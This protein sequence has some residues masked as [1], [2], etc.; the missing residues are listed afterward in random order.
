MRYAEYAPPA[1]LA[2]FIRCFWTF[3]AS[4]DGPC[5]TETIVPD[6]HPELVFHHGDSYSEVTIDASGEA[7]MARQPQCL[8]AGQLT[9]PLRLQANGRRGM[10]GVRFQPAGAG[11]L[12]DMPMRDTTDRWLTLE[13][14]EL[15]W[16]ERAADAV[17]S[18]RDDRTRVAA[19][20][21]ALL[22]RLEQAT[23]LGDPIV[24]ACIGAMR[25]SL[26]RASTARL[27]LTAGLSQRQIE[28]RFEHAVG[29]SP[30][31]LASILRFRAV[32]DALT[33]DQPT[34][35]VCAAI[36]TGYFDQ[37][38]MIRDFRRFAGAPPQAFYRS[39][40]PLSAALVQPSP[41]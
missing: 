25:D 4:N 5:D 34:P 40:G 6:G 32:F 7:R 24:A 13:Q 30:R 21:Q 31:L 41:G 29:M 19:I 18:A 39:I 37:A 2:P 23:P 15:G 35:G 26:H 1:P 28:R 16:L 9:R 22:R 38:H 11:L 20:E 14:L 12:T 10:V 3:E 8:F 36:D 33:A 27:A 17:R